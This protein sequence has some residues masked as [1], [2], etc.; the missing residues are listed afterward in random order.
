M[1]HYEDGVRERAEVS[2]VDDGVVIEVEDLYFE[3]AVQVGSPLYCVP[4]LLL[5]HFIMPLLPDHVDTI[6]IVPLESDAFLV[7]EG[8]VA[9]RLVCCLQVTALEVVIVLVQRIPLRRLNFL[10]LSI[11]AN[12][13]QFSKNIFLAQKL[14]CALIRNN[15]TYH[16][17]R[18]VWHA[19][20]SF[21]SQ[22]IP[23][24]IPHKRI[25]VRPLPLV[26]DLAG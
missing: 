3:T 4:F 26:N 2:A 14:H 10:L 21:E 18:Y 20:D 15:L 6:L 23:L 13:T 19:L 11:H 16:L 17:L 22:A 7:A 8:T 9:L 24:H 25:L 5:R 12:L 1:A